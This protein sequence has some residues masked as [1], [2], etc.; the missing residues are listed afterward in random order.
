MKYYTDLDG[1]QHFI[2][3]RPSKNT[4]DSYIPEPIQQLLKF[5]LSMAELSK[6]LIKLNRKIDESSAT[7]TYNRWFRMGLIHWGEGT[8]FY[9]TNW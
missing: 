6:E 1:K 9:L 8:K 2:D 7:S 4:I 5:G 3:A